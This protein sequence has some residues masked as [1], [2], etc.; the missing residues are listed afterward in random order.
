MLAFGSCISLQPGSSYGI[1]VHMTGVFP[2]AGAICWE[3]LQ[4]F[5]P[6]IDSLLAK[7]AIKLYTGEWSSSDGLS[8]AT[9]SLHKGTLF[10]DQLSY[11]ETSVLDTFQIEGRFALR[12][13]SRKDEFRSVAQSL[14]HCPILTSAIG[15]TR[16]FRV[17][18]T[19]SHILVVTLT[20]MERKIGA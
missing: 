15:L 6:A 11:N 18:L 4:N 16:V 20:G 17:D 8:K 7:R 9:I 1:V 2:D 14:Q 13:T 3:I 12:S 19:A 10:I 5:Q